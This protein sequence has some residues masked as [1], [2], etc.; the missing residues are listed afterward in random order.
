[1][2]FRQLQAEHGAALLTL[3]GEKSGLVIVEPHLDIIPLRS[4]NCL[5]AP[6]FFIARVPHGRF[7]LLDHELL[8]RLADAGAGRPIAQLQALPVI[9]QL[10]VEG[11]G[12][13]LQL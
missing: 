13:R 8:R 5:S 11:G 12:N 10:P 7:E 1:M 2:Q 3:A 6:D 4:D 9:A